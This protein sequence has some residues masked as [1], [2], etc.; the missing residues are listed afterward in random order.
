MPP[1]FLIKKAIFIL[2]VININTILLAQNNLV[3]NPSFDDISA[4]PIN[5][6]DIKKTQEDVTLVR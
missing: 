5:M 4:C 3:L 2:F 6:Y 1:F